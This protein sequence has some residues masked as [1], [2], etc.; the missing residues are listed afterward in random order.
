[1][2]NAK[3]AS[4]QVVDTRLSSLAE[5]ISDVN[6]TITVFGIVTALLVAIMSAVALI[7]AN[8][9][10]RESARDTAENITQQWMKGCQKQLEDAIETMVREARQDIAVALADAKATI[11]KAVEDTKQQSAL[12]QDAIAVTQRSIA[13]GT[14]APLTDPQRQALLQVDEKAKTK[15]EIEYTAKDYL[16]RAFAAYAEGNGAIAAGY[17]DQ[18]AKAA[19]ATP[20]QRSVA[21]L[22]SGVFASQQGRYDEAIARYDDALALLKDA[23][24]PADVRRLALTLTNKAAALVWL[25]DPA[26]AVKVCDDVVARFGDASDQGIL[27]NVARVLT[28]RANALRKMDPEASLD[29]YDAVIQRFGSIDAPSFASSVNLALLNKSDTLMRL[30]RYEPAI[31]A[32]EDLVRRNV[33]KTDPA[34]VRRV[35]MARCNVAEALAMS[36][37]LP[38]AIAGFDEILSNCAKSTQEELQAVL[39]EVAFSRSVALQWAGKRAEALDGLKRLI[40]EATDGTLEANNRAVRRLVDK[41]REYVSSP[42][43]KWKMLDE[44]FTFK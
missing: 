44:T 1:M 32:S 17:F 36:G 23:A 31:A 26:D 3:V 7:T 27:A 5:R 2:L 6:V 19:D 43:T 41:A 12:E 34:S 28:I 9:K 40:D 20:E 39:V 18:A 10:A 15:P 22:N 11:G 33:G 37:K 16:D 42:D 4:M 24:E 13:T 21:L 35:V 8:E 25:D 38:E 29:A 14:A 30:G